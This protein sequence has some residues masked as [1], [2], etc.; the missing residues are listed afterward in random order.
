MATELTKKKLLNDL[1]ELKQM[2]ELPYL[3]LENYFS[4]LRN[5]L[6]N[7]FAP[8]QQELQNDEEKKKVLNESWEKMIKKIDSYEDNCK[9]HS[10]DIEENK[11]EI[12]KIEKML[13][14][15]AIIDLREV[16]EAIK[17]E[18]IYLLKSLFQNKAIFFFKSEDY[19]KTNDENKL[20]N[21]QLVILNDEF[22]SKKLL[23]KR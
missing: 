14:K 15:Q 6:D 22:I 1:N 23:K 11:T 18:E 10:Y 9:R 8:K 3:Y 7:E 12:Y 4:E 20:V 17:K 2:L 13:S 16:E 19:Q 21:G 5:Q